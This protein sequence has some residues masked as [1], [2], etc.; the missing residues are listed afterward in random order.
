MEKESVRDSDKDLSE[1]R[2]DSLHIGV[3][4]GLK[5]SEIDHSLDRISSESVNC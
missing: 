3:V 2:E 1:S 5:R 4:I